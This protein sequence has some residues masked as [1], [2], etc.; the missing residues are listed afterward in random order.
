M[1]HDRESARATDVGAKLGR[2]R[3]NLF[4]RRGRDMELLKA[5]DVYQKKVAPDDHFVEQA[6]V[7][8]I[9]SDVVGIPHVRYNVVIEHPNKERFE[10][11]PRILNIHSF[12]ERFRIRIAS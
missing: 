1:R 8:S 11:G 10:D 7:L 6:R 3:S 5:G 4:I 12:T 2:E 9:F